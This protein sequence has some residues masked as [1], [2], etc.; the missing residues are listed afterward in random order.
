MDL[1]TVIGLPQLVVPS[2]ILDY[3]LSS[4]NRGIVGQNQ[5]ESKVTERTEYAPIVASIFGPK[6]EQ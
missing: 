4:S 3:G 1:S 6:G 2:T 5:Y